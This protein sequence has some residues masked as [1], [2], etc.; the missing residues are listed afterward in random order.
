L[1]FIEIGEQVV[2]RVANGPAIA[3]VRRLKMM[4]ALVIDIADYME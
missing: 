2:S 3:A 1:S 4:N